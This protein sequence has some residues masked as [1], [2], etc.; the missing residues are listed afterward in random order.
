MIAPTSAE[1]SKLLQMLLALTLLCKETAK[2]FASP[3]IKRPYP[4][5]PLAL[6]LTARTQPHCA[7]LL[8]G[9]C[10]SSPPLVLIL[11]L[12]LELFLPFLDCLSGMPIT[13]CVCLL[14]QDLVNAG[15]RDIV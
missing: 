1:R 13:H 11:C 12:L 5:L 9:L 3:E 15:E 6:L 2:K 7:A 4:Q 8:H 10:V 14:L